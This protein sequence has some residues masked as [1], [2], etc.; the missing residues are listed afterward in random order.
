MAT[1]K[2]LGKRFWWAFLPSVEN[3]NQAPLQTF[4]EHLEGDTGTVHDFQD[5]CT[6]PGLTSA[7]GNS[8]IDVPP[9]PIP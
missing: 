6:I 2:S 4:E 1:M 5:E 9:A 8:T 3:G 7:Q